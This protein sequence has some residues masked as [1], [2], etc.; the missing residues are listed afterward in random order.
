MLLPRGGAHVDHVVAD[1]SAAVLPGYVHVEGVGGP[2]VGVVEPGTDHAQPPQLAPMFVVDPV[3]GIVSAPAV[4]V[5]DAHRLALEKL[6]GHAAQG[7]VRLRDDVVEDALQIGLRHRP[8][9]AVSGRHLGLRAD[10]QESGIEVDDRVARH[11][12]AGRVQHLGGDHL[13]G[14]THL[15]VPF[16][17]ELEQEVPLRCVLDGE[18]GGAP[19]E[20]AGG[21]LP[22]SAVVR[23]RE[24]GSL[25]Q[26][27]QGHRL[28]EVPVGE[29]GGSWGPRRG[30]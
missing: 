2:A 8:L 3:V 12:V 5:E 18:A 11:V 25:G 9:A 28:Q 17:I 13:R 22:G 19:L 7:A 1:V 29:P 26:L 23:F 21:D 27:I 20:L 14:R 16:G 15:V 24:T 4:V 6:A 10:L 30:R